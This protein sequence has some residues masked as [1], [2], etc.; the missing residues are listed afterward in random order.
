M[1][2]DPLWTCGETASREGWYSLSVP[3]PD[4]RKFAAYSTSE[5]EDCSM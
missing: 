4:M 1:E 3:G 5:W 2:R